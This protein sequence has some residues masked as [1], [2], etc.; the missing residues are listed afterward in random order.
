MSVAYLDERH[1]SR[2]RLDQLEVHL[3]PYFAPPVYHALR[4]TGEA[5]HDRQSTP[6]TA[7]PAKRLHLRGSAGASCVADAEGERVVG[8]LEFQFDSVATAAPV[9]DR[10]RNKFA[11]HEQNILHPLPVDPAVAEDARQK[12]SSLSDRLWFGYERCPLHRFTD[13]SRHV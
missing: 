1:L 3:G 2:K 13:L 9:M 4:P 6:C 5:G 11:R 8:D 10:V 12:L 7:F